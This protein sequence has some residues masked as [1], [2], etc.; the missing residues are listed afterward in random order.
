MEGRYVLCRLGAG[1]YYLGISIS[2]TPKLE[3]P[4]TR[5]FYP[6]TEDPAAAAILHVSDRVEAQRMDLMLPDAQHDRVIRGTVYWPD[7]RVAEKVNIFLEDPRWPWQSFIV[8]SITGPDGKFAVH[9]L[10][11]TRYRLRAAM[12]AKG[13]VSAEPAPIVPGADPLDLKLIL[14]RKGYS[15]MDGIGQGLENWR[16]GLGLR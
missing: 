7:G 12:P 13:Q 3:Q 11:G 5:W 1:D 16:K 15:P 8:A 9:A 4:Y 10:D 2:S 14:T 6:G